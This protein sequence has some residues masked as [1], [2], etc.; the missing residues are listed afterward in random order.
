MNSVLL[1]KRMTLLRNPLFCDI[2]D[3]NS[4]MD[5]DVIQLDLQMPSV[6]DPI[7]D[8]SIHTAM[9]RE[10]I[11]TPEIYIVLKEVTFEG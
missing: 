4:S 7:K 2:Y 11:Y 3:I 10:Y 8:H 5:F 9:E 1:I 6:S